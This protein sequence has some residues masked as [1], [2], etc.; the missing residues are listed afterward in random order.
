M[1]PELEPLCKASPYRHVTATKQR[2]A[3]EKIGVAPFGSS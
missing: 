1:D 2:E 3:A